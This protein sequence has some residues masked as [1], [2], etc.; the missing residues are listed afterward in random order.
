MS[1]QERRARAEDD[2]TVILSA[3]EAKTIPRGGRNYIV[4]STTTD[5]AVK[6]GINQEASRPLRAGVGDGVP[7]TEADFTE[8]NFLNTTAA[9]QTVVLQTSYGTLIDNRFNAVGG[10]I[11]VEFSTSTLNALTTVQ[12]T[13]L[14]TTQLVGLTSIELG[15][16]A[17]I[18]AVG[19][20]AVKIHTGTGRLGDV[21]VTNVGGASL[22]R[23]HVAWDNTV[24]T[25]AY[26]FR[27][28]APPSSTENGGF[29]VL[30]AADDIWAIGSG[31]D[32]AVS[33]MSTRGGNTVVR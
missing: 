19:T 22:T 11:D 1:I 2:L 9:P 30:P 7:V 6:I 4:I 3:N 14:S 15:E 12:L 16:I 8:L 26:G 23:I 31:A 29:I 28:G 20:S 27:L 10:V 17:A 13:T 24:S 18:V 33:V 32:G 5:G 21:I 25:S